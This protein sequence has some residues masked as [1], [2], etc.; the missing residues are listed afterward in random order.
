VEG[1]EGEAKIIE[2]WDDFE[3]VGE[4]VLSAVHVSARKIRVSMFNMIAE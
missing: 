2:D 3:V 1:E 4:L